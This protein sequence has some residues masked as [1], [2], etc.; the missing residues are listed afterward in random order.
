MSFNFEDELFG[1]IALS[2]SLATVSAYVIEVNVVGGGHG[3]PLTVY[4]VSREPPFSCGIWVMKESWNKVFVY[5][6]V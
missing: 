4:H 1:E 5:D 6:F 2:E 3:N